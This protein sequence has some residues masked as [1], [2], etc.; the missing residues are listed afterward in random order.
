MNKCDVTVLDFA[1]N[2]DN[3]PK[4]GVLKIYLPS[5]SS[6]IAT[7]SAEVDNKCKVTTVDG[8]NFGSV[9]SS[10]VDIPTTTLRLVP[11][12]GGDWVEISN[13]YD[14]KRIY[15]DYT[16][17]P[18]DDKYIDVK[19]LSYM[20]GLRLIGLGM[21]GSLSDLPVCPLLSDFF[22]FSQTERNSKLEGDIKTLAKKFPAITN[23]TINENDGIYGDIE[24]FVAVNVSASTPVLTRSLTKFKVAFSGLSWKGGTSKVK[25][26]PAYSATLAWAPNS[27]NNAYTDITFLSETTTIN[28]H[29]DGTWEYV[30]DDMSQYV[31]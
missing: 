11:P 28:V 19:E 31:G 23:I 3:I 2:N 22:S 10:E 29:N 6:D 9:A 7:F 30:N 15:I 20:T 27:V 17:R 4:L 21:K 24:G 1:T 8:R 26:S 12:T 16:N 18:D 14:M 5:S 25:S 13:K